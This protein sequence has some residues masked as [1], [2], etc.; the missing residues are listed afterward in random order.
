M[1]ARAVLA[2]V[3]AVALRP[4][5]LCAEP[6][7][8][9]RTRR[10]SAAGRADHAAHPDNRTPAVTKPPKPPLR[11]LPAKLPAGLRRNDRRTPGGP[12]LRRRAQPDLDTQGARPTEGRQGDGDLLRGRH[13]RCSAPGA[14]PADRPGGT[15]A[16]QPQLATTTSISARDRSPRSGPTWTAPTRPSRK[17][18]PGA[19]VPFYRQP[20]GRWTPEVVGGGQ[21]PRHA[22]AALVR[23]TRRTG[24]S[25]PRPRS[26]SGS[27]PP[28]APARSCCCT[29]GAA[30]G[31]RRSPPARTLIADLKQPLRHHPTPLD[32]SDLRLCAR[33]KPL[34]D[35]GLVDR[36]GITYAFQASG[37]AGWEQVRLK[38]R[39]CNDGGAALIV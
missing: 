38:L 22:S 35:T 26:A 24:T 32:R 17:A 36:P 1:R 29:T 15:P 28:P 23:S 39:V 20:G 12:D 34:R 2:S 27:T 33:P 13:A 3:L 18:V 7:P 4:V 25:R 19:K 8:H 16:L 9:H 14:G 5:R 10:R 31:P 37:G 6:A 21:G 11:P 30:I